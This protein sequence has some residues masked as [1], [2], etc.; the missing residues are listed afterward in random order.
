MTAEGR[1][2]CDWHMRPHSQA[3][4]IVVGVLFVLF[5][6][7]GHWT[8][9]GTTSSIGLVL[10]GLGLIVYGY[11]RPQIDEG[12]R[13]RASTADDARARLSYS[14][15]VARGPIDHNHSRRGEPLP[16]GEKSLVAHLVAEHG[17]RKVELGVDR[18][19]SEGRGE[20]AYI[21]LDKEHQRQ[22]RG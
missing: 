1:V 18:L 2:L 3:M 5:G 10:I 7:T 22:H 9:R 8:L 19:Y 13:R 4:K 14:E 16:R 21:A 15:R 20:F 11:L 17:D 6:A 12:V